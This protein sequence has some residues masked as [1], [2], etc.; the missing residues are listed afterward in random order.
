[1][2]TQSNSPAAASK[3]WGNR[4][5]HLGTFSS[6]VLTSKSDSR[7]LGP[8]YQCICSKLWVHCSSHWYLLQ[9]CSDPSLQ[10]WWF[11]GCMRH[12]VPRLLPWSVQLLQARLCLVALLASALVF[13]FL[14]FFISGQ[15]NLRTIFILL[16][17]WC[18]LCAVGSYQPQGLTSAVLSNTTIQIIAADELALVTAEAWAYARKSLCIHRFV[19]LQTSSWPFKLY[20]QCYIRNF[21]QFFSDQFD[22]SINCSCCRI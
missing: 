18:L 12:C 6:A 5:N 11:P 9:L 20:H 10:H 14:C 3:K 8:K 7:K 17:C 13:W 4:L 19:N 2:R 21:K 22:W 15:R 1:M 16:K